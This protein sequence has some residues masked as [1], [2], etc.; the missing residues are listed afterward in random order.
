MPEEL[1]DRIEAAILELMEAQPLWERRR[2]SLQRALRALPSA[3]R[4][5]F[6]LRYGHRLAVG[7]M[8]ARLGVNADAVRQQ[9]HQAHSALHPDMQAEGLTP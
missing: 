3:L 8:A 6:E 1:I 9:L 4:Q 5:V 2:E 7:E